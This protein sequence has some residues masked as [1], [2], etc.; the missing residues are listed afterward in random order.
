MRKAIFIEILYLIT[1]SFH[2]LLNLENPTHTERDTSGAREVMRY[3]ADTFLGQ[4]VAALAKTVDTGH[5][6][7]ALATNTC[8]VFNFLDHLK[9]DR[10]GLLDTKQFNNN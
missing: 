10:G 2:L 8:H 1:T 3:H 7:A 9:S 4:R 6:T 5:T